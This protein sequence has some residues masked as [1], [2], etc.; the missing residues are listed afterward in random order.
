MQKKYHH[1]FVT[2]WADRLQVS[3]DD[4]DK[5]LP[6]NG[7]NSRRHIPTSA[8][9]GRLQRAI[10]QLTPTS[11]YLHS[12]GPSVTYYVKRGFKFRTPSAAMLNLK[13]A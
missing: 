8:S 11:V 1:L 9:R 4:L 5:L 10:Q 2:G 6:T 13:I 12:D 3:F 7:S